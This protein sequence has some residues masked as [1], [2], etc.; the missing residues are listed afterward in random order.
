V[1]STL[2]QELGVAK[3]KQYKKRKHK[4]IYTS[5]DPTSSL[6]NSTI[7][8]LVPLTFTKLYKESTPEKFQEDIQHP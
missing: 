5:S 6:N 2:I 8:L 7:E 1:K 3:L 4:E